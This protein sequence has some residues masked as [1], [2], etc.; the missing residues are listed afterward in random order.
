[1]KIDYA[2]LI[3]GDS[4]YVNGVGHFHSPK[5]YELNPSK[6]IGTYLYNF[7]LNFIAWDK[8]DLMEYLKIMKLG[9]LKLFENKDD[10][11]YFDIVTLITTTRPILEQAIGFFID[12]KVKWDAPTKSFVVYKQ[13]NIQDNI[14]DDIQVVGAINRDNFSEVS[15]TILQL[16]YINLEEDKAPAKFES[17]EAKALWEK[18]QQYLQN[19]SKKQA[20]KADPNYELG[21]IISK[22]CCTHNSYNLLNVYNLTIF[23]LYDQFFQTSYLRSIDLNDRIFSNHGGKDYKFENWL[24]PVNQK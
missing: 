23:Q 21:N 2:E 9:G 12:E 17:Q 22:L 20:K 14:Q 6:G 19:Q 15:K 18:A 13:D 11:T 5:L 3:S 10:L 1:M 7:Y 24:K 16:N 8:K 4:I